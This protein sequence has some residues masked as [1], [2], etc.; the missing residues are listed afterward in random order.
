MANEKKACPCSRLIEDVADAMQ[1]VAD[2]HPHLMDY[3]DRRLESLNKMEQHRINLQVAE[4]DGDHPLVQAILEA[5]EDLHM[6]HIL[7]R[8]SGVMDGVPDQADLNW[9]N[10]QEAFHSDDAEQAFSPVPPN[11]TKH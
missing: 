3:F 7:V 6:L 10:A 2:L 11:T 5:Q 1:V 9:D 8:A 4:T